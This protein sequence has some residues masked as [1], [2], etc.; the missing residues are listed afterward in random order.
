MK[1]QVATTTFVAHEF[2]DF[3]EPPFLSE[4]FFKTTS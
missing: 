1:I 3:N 2:V 4:N